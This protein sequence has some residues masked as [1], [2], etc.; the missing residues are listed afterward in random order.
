MRI[1]P[2]PGP[3]RGL[4]E[5]AIAEA[6]ER[7]LVGAVAAGD[8]RAWG[9]HADAA[10]EW[11]GW[12]RAPDEMRAHV[13]LI[14]GLVARAREDGVRHVLV[15]GMGGSSLSPEV[16]R[17][18]FGH[19]AGIELRI[20]DSTDP[21][22]VEAIT[23]GVDPARCLAITSSKSGTTAE[24]LAFLAH[25]EQFLADSLGASAHD[26]LIAITDPGTPLAER[27]VSEGW[28]MVATNPA[29]V[30]GRFSALT[31]FGLIPMAFAGVP[32]LPLL[33]HAEAARSDPEAVRLGV[34]L[35]ALAR[36]GRD[37][38]TLIADPGIGS[39]GLWAE[40]LIAESLGKQGE[41]IIPIADEPIG[42]PDAYG[43]DRVLLHLRLTGE[44][45]A[46]VAAIAAAGIPAF[47]MDIRET[48]DVGGLYMGLEVAVAAAGAVLGVNP[49][50]QPD[51]QAAKEAANRA[52]AGAGIP[53]DDRE[54]PEAIA[55]A[56]DMLGRGD[57]LS[58]LTFS[59]PT[60]AGDRIMS[61]IRTAVRRRT[62]AATTAGWGPRF[63]HSTGQLHKGG[64]GSGVFV[65]LL[66]PGA[67]D[68]PI[69]GQDHTFGELLRAQAIGDAQA[70]ESR[71]RRLVRID[72]G[73][74]PDAGLRRVAR[75]AGA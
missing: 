61:D 39:F 8:A 38:L 69:P 11:T 53:R 64:P 19:G 60:P 62:R 15:L 20:L 4:V 21:V 35:A 34:A 31:L 54:E 63:L 48:L 16:T 73:E 30:G 12:L 17:R 25:V 22:A 24:P 32:L 6:E 41:G 18:T 14:D 40:Q 68:L 5:D 58:L 13:P 1:I 46:D 23:H 7:G 9:E 52:L 36:A 74:D 29:D 45:D 70:L 43:F 65:Q 75:A 67:P 37:K 59:T 50:D 71:G 2:H 42:D 44:H 57:Y 3:A 55:R 56:I 26:H 33:D 72:L 28:R 47:V 10:R 49:F 27:G 51:V 66:G